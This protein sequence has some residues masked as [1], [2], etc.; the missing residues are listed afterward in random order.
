MPK[1]KPIVWLLLIVGA[2][3][4][5]GQA[6]PLYTDW[7]WFQEVGYAQVFV[8][9]LS[10][11]GWLFIGVG[12]GTFLFLYLNLTLAARTA[13]PDALW[14]LEDQLGLPSR[15]VLEP[16]IRRLLLPVLAVVSFFSGV[17]ASGNWETVLEYFNATPFDTT[18]PLFNRDLSFYVFTLP[19]WRLLY[20]W[21]MLLLTATM[22]LGLA[23]YVLQRSL[24]LTARGP[25][26]A[27]GA[28]T[29]L[30]LLGTALLGFK[31]WGFWLDRFDLLFSPR[32]V[33]F[34]ASYSDVNASLP[35]LG[36]LAAL[37]LLCAAACL[38]QVWRP[39][40]RFLA[41]G[42]VV[43]AA[44]WVGGLGAY[45]AL[46]QRF[47]VTPNELV[48]E[49]P[50]IIN[51]I[52]MTRKAFGLDRIEEK[53]FPAEEN[54]TAAALER[55]N[56]TIKNIRLWDHRPLLVTFGQLQE[57]RTYYKFT[58]VDNDR[59]LIGGEYRQIMLSPRELSYR[60]LPSRIWIN[61]HLTYTHGYGVIVGPV[62]RISPEGLPEFFVKDIPPV[63]TGFP[64]ITRPEIYYGEISNDY[65]FVRTK[66]QELDYPAGDQNV[67]TRYAGRGGIPVASFL[68]KLAFAIR[69]G[70]IKIVL[71]DD[72]TGESRIMIHREVAKRVRQIAPFLRFDR[73]P[74]LVITDDGRLVWMI[75]GY[76]VSDR[77]PYSQPVRDLGNYIRNSVKA[78]VDAYHGTVTFY[79]A[80]P[81]DPIIRTYARA[82]PGL[83]KPLGDM[84][85]DLQRHIRYPE[86]LFSIQAKMYATYH[87]EDPQVFY[88]KEDLWA[89]PRRTVEGRDREM[90]PYYTIMRL[91]GEKKE[92]FILLTLFNPSRRDNMIAWLAAR[93]DPPNYGRL[94]VYNFPK[95]KLV[96]GPRQIDARI[97]QEPTISQQ[98]SL[99]NQRGSTTI[100][101]SLLAIPIDQSLIYVQPLY[102]AAA[103]QGALPELRRV[104]VAYGNQI[105]MEPT[106]EQSLQRIFGGR[107]R[108]EDGARP[109]PGAAPPAVGDALRGVAQRAWEAWSRAQEALRRGDWSAYGEEQRRL[110]Q[111]LREFRERSGR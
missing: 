102:L 50:Y 49:G 63:A 8:T 2:L 46:L 98:L 106:L 44:M 94:I 75:D 16:L 100:R 6:V 56:P 10:L 58:D 64:K 86:D 60:H 45:P 39:G 36:I 28:R 101:G 93:T 61:E 14:E 57:I 4:L 32:G 78:T 43:L 72:L 37:A 59:Y 74:Y 77:Y 68:T 1:P 22:G 111:A 71:S 12:L 30:L 80:D 79:L 109:A 20:G 47:R 25:R 9:I 42:L 97:D 11:R 92:E 19:F 76:T 48:A 15:A 69:F 41:A 99:W 107:A 88:N 13:R 103:E 85:A 110:E 95:A 51:N 21:A 91:P 73:D 3:A 35:V 83:F 66:S 81:A 52:R 90:E 82:F 104:F 38:F 27:A 24:V 34:G 65:V 23:L 18:D 55:N 87:M 67:Y 108:V 40:W 7:L 31:A 96:Y 26:L 62:N 70:E 105:A 29:H 89:I 84:P 5:V 54:L 53:D 33:V 17:S